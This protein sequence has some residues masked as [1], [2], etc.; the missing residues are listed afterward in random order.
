MGE[1]SEYF[2]DFPGENPAN[3]VGGRFD[4]AGAAR[5]RAAEQKAKQES[6]ALRADIERIAKEHR[7]RAETKQ[8]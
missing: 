8:N 6:A 1:W 7:R 2:E 5:Q 4:S 3:F